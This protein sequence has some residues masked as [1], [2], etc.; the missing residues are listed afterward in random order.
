MDKYFK[1]FRAKRTARFTLLIA[2]ASVS[3]LF[4]LPIP[5]V[6][7][8]IIDIILLQE[9]YQNIL[10][11]V[12]VM[13]S[14]VAM[15]LLLGRL[16]AKLISGFLQ[17]FINWMRQQLAEQILF[18]KN[19]DSLK[20]DRLIVAIGGD[21]NALGQLSMGILLTFVSSIFSAIGF[22]I[23]IFT[24]NMRLSIVSLLVFPIYI[25]W[26]MYVSRK[27]KTLNEQAQINNER[28]YAGIN[29]IIGNFQIIKIYR[30]M[31]TKLS[32]FSKVVNDVGRFNKHLAMYSNFVGSV[33]AVITTIGAFVPFVAGIMFVKEKTL[34]IGELVA[35]NTY[36]A[37][38]FPVLTSLVELMTKRKLLQVHENRIASIFDMLIENTSSLCDIN[39]LTNNRGI[40]FEN[41]PCSVQT[42]FCYQLN[43]CKLRQEAKS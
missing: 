40:M 32:L 37:M 13:T 22:L 5:L 43:A 6:T 28:L 21:A 15:Q 27:M 31:K 4:S 41:F 42:D 35:F 23:I 9:Q 17:D 19:G 24:L 34:T 7:R 29:E 16:N 39:I 38:L 36:C 30:Y 25:C 3:V 26:I 8:Y 14:I 1:E 20:V 10:Y 33:S 12:I 18:S 2:S 11:V